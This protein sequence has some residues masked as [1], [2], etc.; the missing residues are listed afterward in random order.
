MGE[1]GN[2]GHSFAILTVAGSTLFRVNLPA[3]LDVQLS[4]VGIISS[5]N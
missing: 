4:L 3:C 2:V 5:G 1:C